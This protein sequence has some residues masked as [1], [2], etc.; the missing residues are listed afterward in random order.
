MVNAPN[1]GPKTMPITNT[2]IRTNEAEADIF[3]LNA[4]REP[5]GFAEAALQLGEYRKLAPGPIEEWIFFDHPSGQS[6]I[7][8]AMT[9]KKEHLAELAAKK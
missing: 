3:G 4:S 8:M 1:R 2:I 9:W 6:R 5:D 7:R